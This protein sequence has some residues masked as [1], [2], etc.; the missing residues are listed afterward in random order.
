MIVHQT[1]QQLKL[2]ELPI[3]INVA[4]KRKETGG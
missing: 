1:R 4:G 2:Q 3:G